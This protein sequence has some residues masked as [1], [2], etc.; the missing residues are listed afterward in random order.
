MCVVLLLITYTYGESG[1]GTRLLTGKFNTVK[2]NTLGFLDF[3]NGYTFSPESGTA[4]TNYV[5]KVVRDWPEAANEANRL[6]KQQL[7]WA[8]SPTPPPAGDCCSL[9]GNGFWQEQQEPQRCF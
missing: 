4:I 1:R 9:V 6:T 2:L 8:A 3:P 5:K 7:L